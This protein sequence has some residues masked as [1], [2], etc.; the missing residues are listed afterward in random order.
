MHQAG[1]TFSASFQ[2]P[3]LIYFRQAAKKAIAVDNQMSQQES[4][5]WS[6]FHHT[7]AYLQGLSISV[8]PALKCQHPTLQ[9]LNVP[10]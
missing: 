1:I 7:A 6:C 4:S 10:L 2:V 9:Q 8:K 3:A 5:Q